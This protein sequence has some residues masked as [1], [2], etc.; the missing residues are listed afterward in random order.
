[1]NLNLPVLLAFSNTAL[2]GKV[3][4]TVSLLPKEVASTKGHMHGGGSFGF[5][6][7]LHSYYIEVISLLLGNDKNFYSP[8]P[9]L[10]FPEEMWRAAPLLWVEMTT[11]EWR[12]K[13]YY[14]EGIKVP[15]TYLGLLFM[16]H[17]LL[18]CLAE[19]ERCCLKVLSS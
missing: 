15:A 9:P 3:R 1:M 16:S 11:T 13:S 12:R 7:G 18:W 4:D 5:L 10:T 17:K 14:P 6:C 8:W 2:A 19:A